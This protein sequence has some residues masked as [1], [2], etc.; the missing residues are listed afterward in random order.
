MKL[1]ISALKKATEDAARFCGD[2]RSLPILRHLR[3]TANK[4]AGTL[5]IEAYDLDNYFSRI[6]RG[7]DIAADFVALV[8]CE[9]MM[10]VAKHLTGSTVEL[11]FADSTLRLSGELSYS[12][13]NAA[14]PEDYPVL[15]TPAEEREIPLLPREFFSH[16][17]ALLPFTTDESYNREYSGVLIDPAEGI[18]EGLSLVATDIHRVSVVTLKDVQTPYPF[19]LPASAIPALTKIFMYERLTRVSAF[20]DPKPADPEKKEEEVPA[21]PEFQPKAVRF[22]SEETIVQIRVRKSEFP[23]YRNIVPRPMSPLGHKIE[24]DSFLKKV[25][26]ILT[27][28]DRKIPPAQLFFDAGS[29]TLTSRDEAANEVTTK[30]PVV[31][32]PVAAPLKKGV[33]LRYFVE[34]LVAM[35]GT[36]QVSETD[37]EN[38]CP[39]ILTRETSEFRNLHMVMP[40]RV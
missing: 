15:A 29:V 10:K 17:A 3:L 16:L 1:N 4:E 6:L 2:K 36:V 30:I 25:K 28:A 40:L 27:F 37:P 14:D 22:A 38:L 19:V 34:A 26:G 39:L 23:N 8:P 32:H 24:T 12:I 11:S 5:Q 31:S 9:N 13:K 18:E 33:N 20:T 21:Q 35:A 7:S